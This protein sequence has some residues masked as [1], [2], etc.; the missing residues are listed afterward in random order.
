V[1]WTGA[2]HSSIVTVLRVWSFVDDAPHVSTWRRTLLH[3]VMEQSSISER[4][5]EILQRIFDD[6]RQSVYEPATA[7]LD[8]LE[9][10]LTS[11]FVA[12]TGVAEV[13][14]RE[15]VENIKSVYGA[16]LTLQQ[17]LLQWRDD[18]RANMRPVK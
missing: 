2:R 8:A 4:L 3:G 5:Q 10:E 13:T 6:L 9:E 7:T 11:A 16:R 1:P 15:L 18:F 12:E 17:H 14:V